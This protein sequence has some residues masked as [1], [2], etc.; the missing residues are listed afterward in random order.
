[1]V[2]KNLLKKKDK[3][4]PISKP[5]VEE[6]IGTIQ[7]KDC[8]LV[9]WGRSLMLKTK[10]RNFRLT[11]GEPVHIAYFLWGLRFGFANCHLKEE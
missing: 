5:M 7:L 2:L 1:M 9:L 4:I 3:D 8:E 6:I 11:T 10:N